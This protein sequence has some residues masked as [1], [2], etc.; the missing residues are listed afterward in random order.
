MKRHA[1]SIRKVCHSCARGRLRGCLRMAK[2]A[3]CLLVAAASLAMFPA[4]AQTAMAGPAKMSS[5]W[6]YP[7]GSAV[8][9]TTKYLE[10]NP[11][12]PIAGYY[13]IGIDYGATA[14]T[15]V[16]A[17]SDG[18]V[19]FSGPVQRDRPDWG[20]C[21]FVEHQA[22]DGSTF[23][24]VYMHINSTY[25]LRDRVFAGKPIGTVY[26]DHLHLG[27]FPGTTVPVNHR[28][29]MPNSNWNT[30]NRQNGSVNPQNWFDTHVAPGATVP[31]TS[32]DVNT[33][34]T[35]MRSI[36][37]NQRRSENNH[38]AHPSWQLFGSGH[39][40]QPALSVT[41]TPTQP[42]LSVTQNP[43]QQT[44]SVT[45][46]P[47]QPTLSVTQNPV[48]QTVSV[49]Q[50]PTQP[51]LSVTQNPV[52]QTVSVTPTPTQPTLSVVPIPT[53]P[54]LSVAP[55]S[56]PATVVVA[57]P[58]PP[59]NVWVE[60]FNRNKIL[61]DVN[62]N[63]SYLI[64]ASGRRAWIPT[65]G[66]YQAMVNNSVPVV[67]TDWS[68]ISRYPDAGYQAAV[69]RMDDPAISGPSQW[70]SYITG[71]AG[72]GNDYAV[73]QSAAGKSYVTNGATWT[74]TNG[75]GRVRVNAFI[76]TEKAVAGVVYQIFDGGT[77]LGSVSINQATSFGFVQLGTWQFSSGT[78]VVKVYDNQG[79]GPYGSLMGFDC[80]EGIPVG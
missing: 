5:G 20:N 28:G 12:Y 45:Q 78:I 40:I 75:H 38:T 37:F 59:A 7:L 48:Q 70:I 55:P 60:D 30:E 15:T 18:T 27:V 52:Q 21:L 14:G 64:T 46:T 2:I 68:V 51:T 71:P 61:T 6:F 80:V 23:L 50:T 47:T 62:S 25:A 77:Y 72:Y 33:S 57:P 26:L 65:G 4:F 19:R 9:P 17:V 49:T 3:I 73:T 43:V 24:V 53:Q 29:M 74:L 76:P 8:A 58:N 66:D 67:R 16:Y 13:H 35:S 31:A 56:P 32:A 54:T 69:T 44:V 42:T 22:A 34:S 39:V 11:T 10:Q 36:L 63:A 1:D 79:S 41:Q